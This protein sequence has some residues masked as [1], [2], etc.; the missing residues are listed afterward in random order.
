MRCSASGAVG[1]LETSAGYDQLSLNPLC[2]DFYQSQPH[3]WLKSKALPIVSWWR[4][5]LW[6]GRSDQISFKFYS[7]VMSMKMAFTFEE[8]VLSARPDNWEQDFYWQRHNKQGDHAT[9]RKTIWLMFITICEHLW[10][11]IFP[12][13]SIFFFCCMLQRAL[14]KVLAEFSLKYSRLP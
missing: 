13:S 12:L 8:K 2:H 14:V 10:Q 11:I 4:F 5:T 6:K 3:L 1:R 7:Q 9:L